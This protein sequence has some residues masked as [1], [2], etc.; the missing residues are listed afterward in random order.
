MRSTVLRTI[1]AVI[2]L[3]TTVVVAA[4]A[5]ASTDVEYAPPVDAPV[6]DPFRPPATPYGPGNRGIEFGTDP[7][8]AVNAAAD[9]TGT[10]AGSVA[11]RRW[12]TIRHADGVRTTYGPLADVPVAAGALVH[13]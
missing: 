7:G 12:V 11:G 4:P 1:T 3:L 5:A 9:G 6:S 13:R 8:V 2:V 10:F